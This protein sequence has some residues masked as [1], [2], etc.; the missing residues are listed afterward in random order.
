MQ[1]DDARIKV[2]AGSIVYIKVYNVQCGANIPFGSNTAA[3][4][5]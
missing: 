5:S 2:L 1:A 3:L 4:A